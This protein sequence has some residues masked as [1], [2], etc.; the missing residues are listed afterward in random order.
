MR[1]VTGLL[2]KIRRPLPD[3]FHGITDVET[4]YRQRYLDLLMNE[5]SRD[6]AFRRARL[7][8]RP[9]REAREQQALRETCAA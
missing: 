5:G 3:R 2:A 7:R 4:R 8:T 1:C 6:L 9:G